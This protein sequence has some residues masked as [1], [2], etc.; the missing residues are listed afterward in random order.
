VHRG[1]R[2]SWAIRSIGAGEAGEQ[3]LG[4]RTDKD[5]VEAF[6]FA[7]ARGLDRLSDFPSE[8]LA[9]EEKDSLED[10]MLGRGSDV[11]VESQVGEKGFD[12]LSAHFWGGLAFTM[13]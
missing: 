6:G 9:I 10:P 1:E 3:V 4:F 12:F 5:D 8:D 11:F 13:K 7:G 2:R